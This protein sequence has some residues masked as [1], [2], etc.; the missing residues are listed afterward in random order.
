[1]DNADIELMCKDADGGCNLELK[2]EELKK[3]EAICNFRKVPCN[4]TS[5]DEMIVVSKVDKHINEEHQNSFK[6]NNTHFELFFENNVLEDEYLDHALMVWTNE[7]G[8]TFYPQIYKKSDLW[9]FWIKALMNPKAAGSFEITAEVKN[10]I[11]GFKMMYNGPVIS[12]DLT[13]EEVL[14]TGHYLLMNRYIV[15]KL[16]AA[17]DKEDSDVNFNFDIK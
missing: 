14:K 10:K 17:R 11:T 9:Y 8:K 6:M 5:C 15:E 2:N 1:M 3:H 13:V 12:I 4:D 16:V 7:K